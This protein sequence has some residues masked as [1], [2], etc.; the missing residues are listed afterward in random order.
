MKI[1][2]V[3]ATGRIGAQL[4]RKLLRA[5]HRVRALSRGGPP[6]DALAQAGAEP[7]LGSFDTGSGE[8]GKFFQGADTREA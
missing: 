4:T 1:A 6:L 3:G 5:G 8:L 7:F 2:V